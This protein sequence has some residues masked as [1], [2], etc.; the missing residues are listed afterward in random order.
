MIMLA[1]AS[2][3]QNFANAKSKTYTLQDVQSDCKSCILVD[4]KSNTF[5]YEKDS[6]K[7]LPIASMTKLVSLGVIFNAID[8]GKLK[9]EQE[10]LVSSNAASAEGSEAFLDANNKYKVE[11]LIL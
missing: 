5:I 3:N 9:L 7:K 11:D 10:I 6:D 4:T 2:Y 8:N 1:V